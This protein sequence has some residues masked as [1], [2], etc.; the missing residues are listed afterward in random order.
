[1]RRKNTS[2]LGHTALE[3]VEIVLYIIV[4]MGLVMVGIGV[5]GM[6]S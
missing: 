5:V 6:L 3:W 4:A 2:N 1:M